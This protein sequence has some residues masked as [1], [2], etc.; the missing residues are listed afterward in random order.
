ML[1]N[2]R[3]M[4]DQKAVDIDTLTQ[5]E[6]PTYFNGSELVVAGRLRDSAVDDWM[7]EVASSTGNEEKLF[8]KHVE[9]TG[10]T[11]PLEAQEF[12][13]EGFAQK[14]WATARIRYLLEKHT[15]VAGLKKHKLYT[16]ALEMALNYKLVTPITNMVVT[17]SFNELP[18]YSSDYSF[19][20][21]DMYV[22]EMGLDKSI[23]YS[24]DGVCNQRSLAIMTFVSLVCVVTVWYWNKNEWYHYISSPWWRHQME[25][26]AR[27]W[28]FL[29]GI[30]RSRLI[31]RTKASDAKLWCFLWPSPE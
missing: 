18:L 2:V 14:L 19:R 4:Y 25:H 30:H 22:E 10:I 28:P 8:S 20:S 1:F 23:Y 3:M 11:I 13:S 16:E 26:F 15:I 29:R 24:N 12:Y 27:Y 17:Q 5:T 6:F 9:V 21:R 31:P 7:V